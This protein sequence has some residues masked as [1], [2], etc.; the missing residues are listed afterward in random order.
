MN[1]E[2]K[3]ALISWTSQWIDILMKATRERSPGGVA[4]LI[5]QLDALRKIKPLKSAYKM[6]EG[7]VYLKLNKEKSSRQ[8]G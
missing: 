5:L 7:G 3:K 1:N 2:Y 4:A 8:D 6:K